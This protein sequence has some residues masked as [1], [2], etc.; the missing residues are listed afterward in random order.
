MFGLVKTA[1]DVVYSLEK[2]Q[3][4][5]MGAHCC[6]LEWRKAYGDKTPFGLMDTAL[7]TALVP[8][9]V[10]TAYESLKAGKSAAL[11]R[12]QVGQEIEAGVCR[13]HHWSTDYFFGEISNKQ[14]LALLQGAP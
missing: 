6:L 12:A 8:E 14:I 2:S 9:T 11:S 1:V 10:L 3:Q 13:L 5:K 4:Y 7:G